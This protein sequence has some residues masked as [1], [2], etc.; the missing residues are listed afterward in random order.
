M[1]LD[2]DGTLA[3]LA[4]HPNLTIME[5][6]TERSLKLLAKHPDVYLGIISGRSA[7]NVREKVGI[8]NI[9]YAGNHG[10]EIDY[11]NK[12]RFLYQLPKEMKAN[13]EKLVIDLEENVSENMYCGR[14]VISIATE[15]YGALN[16]SEN[17]KLKK[18]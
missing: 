17:E 9:T 11:W 13:F 12:Q 4:A 1:F 18:L 10:L 16:H 2:Y 3:P 15:L 6:E 7:E 14:K 8:E 5:P